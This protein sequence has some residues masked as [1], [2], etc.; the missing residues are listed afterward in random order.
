MQMHTGLIAAIAVAAARAAVHKIDVGKGGKTYTPDVVKA[1][2]GDVLEFR[3]VGGTHDAVTG[4]MDRPCQPARKK[5]GAFSSGVFKGTPSK[6]GTLAVRAE[7]AMP[8]GWRILDGAASLRVADT[9]KYWKQSEVFKVTVNSKDPMMVYCSV[10]MHC[11]D[12]M[13]MVINPTG[14]TSLDAFKAAAKGKSGKA[15]D[16]VFG[17][18]LDSPSA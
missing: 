10:G 16:G 15:P 6:V 12:G 1:D 14:D 13:V 2:K 17:G 8:R 11:S 5:D 3:F 4:D 18:Q 9:D 7:S